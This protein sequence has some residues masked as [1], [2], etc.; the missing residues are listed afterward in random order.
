MPRLDS[1]TSRSSVG[2][3]LETFSLVTEQH[4]TNIIEVG[5]LLP[6]CVIFS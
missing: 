4:V 5:L 3:T 2:P 1:L 6:T